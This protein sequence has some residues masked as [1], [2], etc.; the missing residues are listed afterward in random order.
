MKGKLSMEHIVQF[1]I[2]IDDEVIKKRVEEKAEK[3]IIQSIKEDIS[4]TMFERYYSYSTPKNHIVGVKGFA[5]NLFKEFIE[6]NKDLII[7]TA[8]KQL[9]D[10]LSRKKIVKDKLEQEFKKE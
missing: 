9:I 2:G 3:E 6:E 5:E 4:N 1:G 10:S 8:V 7:D